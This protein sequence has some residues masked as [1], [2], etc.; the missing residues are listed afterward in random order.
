M[1]DTTVITLAAFVFG[2]K[3]AILGGASLLLT[4]YVINMVDSR[5]KK[6]YNKEI[7]AGS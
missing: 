5:I 3:S 6:V 4:G 7:L 1:A 2:I